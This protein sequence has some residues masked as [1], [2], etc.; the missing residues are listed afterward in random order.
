MKVTRTYGRRVHETLNETRLNGFQKTWSEASKHSISIIMDGL[1]QR[2]FSSILLLVVRD[3]CEGLRSLILRWSHTVGPTRL[4]VHK[5]ENGTR[6]VTLFSPKEESDPRVVGTLQWRAR[7]GVGAEGRGVLGTTGSPES[8]VKVV[9]IQ[10]RLKFRRRTI[11]LPAPPELLYSS[12]LP[13]LPINT[14]GHTC[15]T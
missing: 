1:T 8:P 3:P 4:T 11:E 5:E 9:L 6:R 14:F 13:R 7:R 12:T 15:R 2:H 10:K